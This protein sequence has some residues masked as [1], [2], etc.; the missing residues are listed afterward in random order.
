MSVDCSEQVVHVQMQAQYPMNPN[1]PA[2]AY[3]A[4]GYPTPNY[5]QQLGY[6]PGPYMQPG[7]NMQYP[8][9]GYPYGQM[10]PQAYAPSPSGPQMYGGPSGSF[11]KQAGY[12][13][14]Y[15]ARGAQASGAGGV[16]AGSGR[17]RGRG[18]N[19]KGRMAPSFSPQGGMLGDPYNT[20]QAGYMDPGWM[21]QNQRF[22]SGFGKDSKGGQPQY[23]PF[24]PGG[25]ENP[26]YTYGQFAQHSQFPQQT[27]NG[28]EKGVGGA[29]GNF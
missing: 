19:Q 20:S 7:Y 8:N 3:G 2:P 5:P 1:M 9:S 12:M 14:D 15:N 16:P 4:P 25:Y 10:A 29:K 11:G 22:D 26:P 18:K 13:G 17:G 28:Q 6:A 23:H 21:A 24:G 27:W